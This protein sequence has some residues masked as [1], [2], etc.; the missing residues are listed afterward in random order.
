MGSRGQPVRIQ[1]RALW[2]A[3]R[4]LRMRRSVARSI[5]R[6]AD[7]ALRRG[8]GASAIGFPYGGAAENTLVKRMQRTSG[9]PITYPC[10]TGGGAVD[11]RQET[12]FVFGPVED[13]G[14]N[15]LEFMAGLHSEVVSEIT[16]CMVEGV[17]SAHDIAGEVAGAGELTP[18]SLPERVVH[19]QFPDLGDEDAVLAASQPRF[20][21][22]LLGGDPQVVVGVQPLE[23]PL[24]R[25]HVRAS[26]GPAP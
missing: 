24:G 13:V 8:S 2:R 21:E 19:Q 20:D 1:V 14:L 9:S 5:S 15:Q 7:G 11:Q 4:I 10:V 22:V 17:E 6:P 18:G 16:P 12:Q 23:Q 26:S 3:R 25:R